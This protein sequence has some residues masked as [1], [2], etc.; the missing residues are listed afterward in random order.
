MTKKL[1]RAQVG[2]DRI[3]VAHEFAACVRKTGAIVLDDSVAPNKPKNADFWFSAYN[4]VGELKQRRRIDFLSPQ[5][6]S[7]LLDFIHPGSH[8]A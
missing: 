2:T 8:A 6:K 5:H 1:E 3:H 4:V 7:D